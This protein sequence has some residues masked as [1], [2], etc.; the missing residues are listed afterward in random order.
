M[1]GQ[2]PVRPLLS[3]ETL[4]VMQQRGKPWLLGLLLKHTEHAHRALE[5]CEG[6]NIDIVSVTDGMYIVQINRGAHIEVI[7]DTK[8]SFAAMGSWDVLV[9]AALLASAKIDFEELP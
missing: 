4:K 2:K 3:P 7:V 5:K 6:E 8:E 9:N 1:I